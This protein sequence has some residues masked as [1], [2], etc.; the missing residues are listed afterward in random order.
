[1]EVSVDA[2]VQEPAMLKMVV[3]RGP[4]PCPFEKKFEIAMDATS[5]LANPPIR[6]LIRRTRC[7]SE[8]HGAGVILIFPDQS[9]GASPLPVPLDGA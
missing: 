2:L 1:M 5:L 4:W 7:E 8:E 9:P 6:N 3:S